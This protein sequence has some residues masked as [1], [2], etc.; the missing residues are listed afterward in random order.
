M[1]KRLPGNLK[2]ESLWKLNDFGFWNLDFGLLINQSRM[3]LPLELIGCFKPG[4]L[5]PVPPAPIK[6][7][8]CLC[9]FPPMAVKSKP[10]APRVVGDSG[11]SSRFFINTNNE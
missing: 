1:A 8:P 9:I 4:A 10:P 5:H 6:A 7:L 11:R 3:I 2:P